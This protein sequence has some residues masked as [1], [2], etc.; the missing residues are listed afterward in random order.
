MK[1]LTYGITSQNLKYIFRLLPFNYDSPDVSHLKE[2]LDSPDANRDAYR[3]E[4]FK[5][6]SFY[7][8]YIEN[9]DGDVILNNHN[10]TIASR[11]F[12]LYQEVNN[13][14]NG[15]ITVDYNIQDLDDMFDKFL[16]KN[17]FA[18]NE[19]QRKTKEYLDK[20]DFDYEIRCSL[21]SNYHDKMQVTYNFSRRT[22]TVSLIC[23]YKDEVDFEQEF[24]SY[25]NEMTEFLT[26]NMDVIFEKEG[27]NNNDI[28]R[29]LLYNK[30][31]NRSETPIL[32]TEPKL[33]VPKKAPKKL[34]KKGIENSITS[35]EEINNMIKGIEKE[36]KVMFNF[37]S[38]FKGMEFGAVKGD[39]FKLCMYGIAF[40]NGDG[41]V[42]YDKNNSD[43]IDVDAMN[44]DSNG[45][46]MQMP[47]A[48]NAIEAGDIILHQG[49]PVIVNSVRDNGQIEVLQPGVS[50]IKTILPVK[51]MFGFNFVTKIMPLIDFSTF[52]ASNDNPF[53]NMMP[54]MMMTN[55]M[56]GEQDMM[57]TMLMMNMMNGGSMDMKSLMPLM[58]LS[59]DNND[60]D[61][62]KNIMLMNMM[63]GGEM[64]MQTMMP[65]MLLDR[66]REDSSETSMIEMFMM[67]SMFGQGENPFASMFSGN[68]PQKQIEETKDQAENKDN[69]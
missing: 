33:K 25:T 46:I 45:M 52:G 1:K 34:D 26:I 64:D 11:L 47:V 3:V 18:D 20:M 59:G 35:R 10:T 50:E 41:Y 21:C 54:L 67:M 44:F 14:E 69:E 53:G 61:M 17:S 66:K 68:K 65:L 37:K 8:Y 24:C 16:I 43:V 4:L 36:N 38:M 19:A 58:L 5:E 51:N 12:L 32:N 6:G 22:F 2:I 9:R 39:M 55:M 13:I 57:E 62:F 56:D 42:A 40:K 7:R 23:P 60:G 30:A 28:R 48:I 63:S 31:T 29:P 49:N 15:K 27:V